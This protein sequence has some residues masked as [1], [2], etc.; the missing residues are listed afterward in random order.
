MWRVRFHDRGRHGI[1]TASRIMGTA[2]FVSVLQAQD[3]PIY[4]AERR[5]AQFTAF[6]RIDTQPI[7]ERGA[8]VDPDLGQLLVAVG[9]GAFSE[10]AGS[11]WALTSVR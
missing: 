8:V 2:A 5:G 3:S 11:N 9:V 7:C 10:P 1:K 4:G 6:T